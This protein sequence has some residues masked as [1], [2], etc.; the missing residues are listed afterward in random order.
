VER[1]ID[2]VTL[3]RLLGHAS[4]KMTLDIY[5]DSTMEQRR[6]AMGVLDLLLTKNSSQ[7]T[8]TGM[9]LKG[10]GKIADL[11]MQTAARDLPAVY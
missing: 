4:A 7:A 8:D 2:I 11:I 3:S 9:L 5:A 10:W 1:G 6:A